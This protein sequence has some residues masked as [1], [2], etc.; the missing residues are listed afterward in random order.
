MRAEGCVMGAT[1]IGYATKGL[2]ALDGLEEFK[3]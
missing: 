1:G 3:P 2:N